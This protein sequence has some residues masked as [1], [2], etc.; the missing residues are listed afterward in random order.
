[1]AFNI[2]N[3]NFIK[4]IDFTPEEFKFLIK[5]SADLKAAKYA[6]HLKQQLTGKNIALI[7]EKTSTRT[8][9]AFEVAAALQGA[10]TTYLD[11]TGSQFGHKESAKDSARV[12]G[13]FYDAIEW[14]GSDHQIVQTLADH[15][16]VPVY[17]GLCDDWHPTQSLCDILTMQEHGRGKQLHEL[18]YAYLGDA[19]NNMCHSMMVSAALI[20]ADFRVAAPAEYFPNPEVVRIAN[21]IAEKTGAK[22]TVTES[23]ADAV[24]GVD[25]IHTDV[26]LSMGMDKS[27]LPARIAALIPYQT[28][29][30]VMNLTGNPNVKFMHCLPAFHDT[31]TKMGKEIAETYGLPNGVEV[32]DEVFESDASVVFQQAEN[33]LWTIMA[34]MVAT[35]A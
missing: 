29:I 28:N 16:G 26:F 21:E 20:G 11:P 32:T 24:N 22:I 14:R 17:N 18:K 35:L 13:R 34:V 9:C 31:N 4:E 15:A 12:L 25:F 8:R 27:E 3:R 23:V 7:F 5:L 1:M 2:K 33:R 19:A 10:S 30:D 6:G